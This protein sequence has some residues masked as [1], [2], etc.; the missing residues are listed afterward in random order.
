MA[1][2]TKW[3]KAKRFKGAID[4]KRGQIFSKPTPK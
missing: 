1:G 2:H 3:S 4:A